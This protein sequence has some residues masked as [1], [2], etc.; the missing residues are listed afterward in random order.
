[1]IS[2][3]VALDVIEQE[4]DDGPG[5]RARAHLADQQASLSHDRR[6]AQEDEERMRLVAG[7]QRTTADP[8][9]ARGRT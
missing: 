3:A 6:R 5:A 2:H 8:A 7:R 9:P 4:V 1:L